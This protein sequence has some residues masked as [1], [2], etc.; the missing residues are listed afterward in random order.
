MRS[1][2]KIMIIGGGASGLFAAAMLAD[3]IKGKNIVVLE[4]NERVGKKL[5]QTGN[6]QGNLTN[7]DLSLKYFHSNESDFPKY[8][9]DKYGLPQIEDFYKKIGV[10]LC[11][12]GKRY[13]VSKQANAVTDALRFYL[14]KQG[15]TILTETKVTG[16]EKK[17]DVFIAETDNGTFKSD[18][19]IL[20]FGGKAGKPYGTDGSAYF[21]AENFGHT[22]TALYPSLVQLKTQTFK[23]LKGIKVEAN[24][25]AVG[26]ETK[27][28]FGDLLFTEYGVSGNAVFAV[29]GTVAKG[30]RLEVEFLPEFT[31]EEVKN[32]LSVRKSLGYGG[33]E[34]TLGLLHKML[35]KVI[36]ESSNRTIED[37]AAKIKKFPITVTGTLDFNF[38]QVTKGGIRV[39]EVD[40]KTMQSKFES[41]MYIVGEALDVDGDCGGY[42]LHWAYA[43]AA[44]AC[45][46]I[47]KKV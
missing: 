21:L 8:A 40:S 15:V 3:K 39:C 5:S 18:F 30:G 27:T 36:Y 6:G 44:T 1:F 46:D 42:N 11:G 12:N 31:F 41:G 9:L 4:K 38:A 17:K 19:A 23:G 47:C 33:E 26:E 2:F 43:S 14:E 22:L 35:G 13:P 32:M 29:S 10:F 7:S 37:Y 25:T 34:L 16:L 45:D 28:S 20:A 24:I